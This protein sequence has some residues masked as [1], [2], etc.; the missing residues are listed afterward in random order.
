[1]VNKLKLGIPK[2]SLERATLE[3]FEKSGWQIRTHTRNYFPS[4]DD[5]EVTCALVRAQEMPRYVED[6]TLDVG[7]TG[8]DWVFENEADVEVVCD[9]VYSKSSSKPARWVVAVAGDSPIAKLS[10]LEGKKVSTELVN[11]TKAYFSERGIRVDVEF[12]WGATEAKV[13]EGLVD[14]IVEITETESTIRAHGLKIIHELMET[15]TQLVAN[16]AAWADPWKREKIEQMAILLRSA[17]RAERMV[18]LKMNAPKQKLESLVKLLPSVTAPTISPLYQSEW[19]SVETVI[20]EENVR[21]L[22]PKL[23]R[24][25][26]KG[27][28][29]YSLNKLI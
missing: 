19:V 23:M 8:K 16:K 2:G 13:V 11:Y 17:L 18:G 10:D 9:L 21:E 14:A 3:L 29:E 25:G 28:I 6:G 5:D 15:N 7:L 1:M 20:S 26:A 27:I 24:Q 4:I 22:I 12:S